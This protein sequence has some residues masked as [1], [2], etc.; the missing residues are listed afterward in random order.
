MTLAQPI[1]AITGAQGYLGTQLARHLAAQGWMIRRLSQTG[2]DADYRLGQKPHP[3][4]LAGVD[5][6]IHCAFDFSDLRST[7]DG[8]VNGVGTR[9]I[10]DAAAA[11][12]V[13]RV[14][15]I[16][17]IAAYEGCRSHY[18][19]SKLQSEQD[20]LAAGALVIRPGLIYGRGGGL[21][22]AM[23]RLIDRL[24]L[25][26]L[27]G[28]GRWPSAMCQIDDLCSWIAAA[29]KEDTGPAVVTLAHPRLWTFRT[30]LEAGAGRPVR[31]LSIPWRLIWA[32]LRC[33][34]AVG[35]RPPFRS[36]SVIGLV[37]TNPHPAIIST[38]FRAYPDGL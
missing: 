8:G 19:Q 25:V 31:F 6:L 3:A 18:G 37:Y 38:G 9:Q 12:G 13:R 32:G 28:H 33:L 4:V 24:P 23:G 34:E 10:L 30:M 17:S 21:V 20:A 14:I 27:I 22:A 7:A 29:L 36:D 26:P 15:F 35:I 5:A 16:S 2:G 1:C 11:A